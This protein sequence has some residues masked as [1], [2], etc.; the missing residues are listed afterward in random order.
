MPLIYAWKKTSSEKESKI[1]YMGDL[2]LQLPSTDLHLEF[3]TGS[4]QRLFTSFLT[5]HFWPT[6]GRLRLLLVDTWWNLSFIS[7]RMID[8]DVHRSTQMV[9]PEHLSRRA[10][11]SYQILV[12][13]RL[14]LPIID[15]LRSFQVDLST[16]VGLPLARSLVFVSRT[17]Q[18]YPKPM[19]DSLGNIRT[20]L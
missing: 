13:N 15:R 17:W 19:H 7:Q 16:R 14:F 8:P 20:F 4:T 5:K 18:T 1:Y 9:D 11:F 12:D 3:G 6:Q 2:H 10:F